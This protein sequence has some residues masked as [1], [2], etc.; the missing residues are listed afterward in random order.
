MVGLAY[1]ILRLS[2]LPNRAYRWCS[3]QGQGS[4]RRL[5]RG[6]R[7]SSLQHNVLLRAV[8]RVSAPRTGPA[9]APNLD[10]VRLEC[11]GAQME[12]KSRVP[13]I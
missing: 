1:R 7:S 11:F 13:M 8:P 10:G 5:R 4:S 3:M 6:G 2:K 9:R 12:S